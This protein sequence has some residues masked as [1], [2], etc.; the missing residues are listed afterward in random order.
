M[1]PLHFV[2]R[3]LPE[4]FQK[5][6]DFTDYQGDYWYR[7]QKDHNYSLL[8]SA[9]RPK[10][11]GQF[12]DHGP[13]LEKDQI[14]KARSSLFDNPKT[15][16]LKNELDWLCFLQHVGTP[17]RLLDF[18]L[19]PAIALYFAF[20]NYLNKDAPFQNRLPSVWI[21]NLN[22]LSKA[23]KNK[24]KQELNDFSCNE[25]KTNFEVTVNR[26]R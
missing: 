21:L 22:E 3:S 13:Q 6:L 14:A 26:F 12:V 2:I 4:F 24:I 15:N 9:Y 11:L 18:T 7:G 8:P 5:L 19:S 20:S 17:T 23:T 1:A 25:K 16:F 10:N